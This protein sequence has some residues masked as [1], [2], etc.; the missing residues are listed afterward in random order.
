MYIERNRDACYQ[1][2]G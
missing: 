1:D 2:V